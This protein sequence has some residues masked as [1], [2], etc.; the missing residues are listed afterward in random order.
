MRPN[1]G[2]QFNNRYLLG[3]YQGNKPFIQA[4]SNEIFINEGL[5]AFCIININ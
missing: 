2:L 5:I 1:T 4:L 3:Q